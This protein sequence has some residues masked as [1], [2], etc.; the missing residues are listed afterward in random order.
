VIKMLML[1]NA[2]HMHGCHAVQRQHKQS[3]G[4]DAGELMRASLNLMGQILDRMQQML[5]SAQAGP[6]AA[7]AAPP[8]A[9]GAVGLLAG[10][11]GAELSKLLQQMLSG[12]GGGDSATGQSGA[13]GQGGGGS[14][15]GI[16]QGGPSLADTVGLTAGGAMPQAAVSRPEAASSSGVPA[17]APSGVPGAPDTVP[18]RDDKPTDPGKTAD[19]YLSANNGLLKNLGNQ[20]GMK[21]KLKD[22]YGDWDDPNRSPQDRAQSAY[23]ASR[24]LGII[25][26]KSNREGGDRG[27]VVDNGKMEG[28][29]KDGDI[30]DGTEMGDLKNSLKDEPPVEQ[31][32]DPRA[33]DTQDKNTSDVLS[34]PNL[35]DTRD[36]HVR[37]DG[38]NRNNDAV[39]LERAGRIIGFINPALGAV[40]RGA[41][42][43]DRDHEVGL[44]EVF[45]GAAGGY[46]HHLENVGKGVLDAVRTGRINPLS[47]AVNVAQETVKDNAIGLANDARDRDF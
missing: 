47:V 9:N 43:A 5:A 10:G 41:G 6:G 26:H 44:G 20:E 16:W 14:P 28:A 46:V 12:G 36:P 24:H 30:R 40:L 18:R 23:N 17:G 39:N 33:W 27:D 11:L 19:D 45:R 25:K 22:R 4:I 29:T 1:S 13:A 42:E 21:D 8:A 31:R 37:L 38:T 3:G 35:K 15:S 34:N 32:G 2:S 7:A